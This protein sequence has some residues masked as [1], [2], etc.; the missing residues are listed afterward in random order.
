[1]EPLLWLIGAGLA[2]KFF[3]S[4]KKGT[5]APPAPTPVP[6]P[7]PTLPVDPGTFAQQMLPTLTER[8][9]GELGQLVRQFGPWFWRQGTEPY[10]VPGEAFIGYTAPNQANTVIQ[11][12][13][14]VN[15]EMQLGYFLVPG[16]LPGGTIPNVLS[17]DTSTWMDLA[18][19]SLIREPLGGRN[20]TIDPAKWT[21]A[22]PDQVALGLL[23]L[24]LGMEKLLTQLAF[25]GTGPLDL[26]SSWAVALAFMVGCAGSTTTPARFVNQYGER[27]KDVPE[28][29][30]FARWGA[31]IQSD[32]ESGGAAQ[33]VR[34]RQRNPG[35]AYIAVWQR[36]QAG[37]ALAKSI[38]TQTQYS[39]WWP[40][41]T[42]D[43]TVI[44]RGSF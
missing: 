6:S 26:Q 13:Q 3:G 34:G 41:P 20:A 14:G 24:R 5:A 43:A 44:I 42:A 17:E 16:G 30:R 11:P 27:L 33:W 9:S 32:I 15:E 10:K 36:M 8:W 12:V 21:T 35:A 39:A 31:M 40:Q 1:M 38:G 29:E 19:E 25:S 37:Y 7:S 28:T 2:L 18:N 23:F 4:K 22:I